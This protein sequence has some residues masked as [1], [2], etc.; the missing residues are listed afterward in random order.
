M[1]PDRYRPKN[2]GSTRAPRDR[3]Y[4]FVK[5]EATGNDFILFDFFSSSLPP[6][7]LTRPEVISHLCARRSGVG[8]DGI[9]FLLPGDREKFRMRIFNADGSEAEMC[10]NGLRGLVLYL[11]SQGLLPGGRVRVET[12]A[13]IKSAWIKNDLITIDLGRARAFPGPPLRIENQRF[14]PFNVDIGNPHAVIFINE[15]ILNF[16]VERFGPQIESH[17][18]YPNR[19]N[20]EFV[21]VVK[22]QELRARVW[23][24]GVGET[25]SCGTGAG[26]IFF[27]AF[28]VKKSPE[29]AKIILPGGELQVEQRPDGMLY[30][31]GPARLIFRGTAVV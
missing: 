2:P 7:P 1:R 12:R 28:T 27:A 24:R 6:Q 11:D 21:Q 4:P 23:E 3:V 8:A 5:L 9:L 20:V 16:P 17:S 22:P 14:E 25:P 30:L 13:G 31:T 18:A 10:G 29:K 19:T 15:D 26:A